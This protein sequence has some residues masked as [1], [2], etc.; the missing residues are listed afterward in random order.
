MGTVDPYTV[1]HVQEP[2]NNIGSKHVASTS[3]GEFETSGVVVGIGPH[4]I[5]EGPLMWNLFDPLYLLDVLNVHQAG[6]ESSVHA[7]D[8]VI[9]DRRK[10]QIIEQ[11]CELLPH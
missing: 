1:I 2:L 6:G 4:Q 11:V 10:R 7:E 9:D 5:G 3:V 8:P